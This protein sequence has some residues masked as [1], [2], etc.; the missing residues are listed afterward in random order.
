MR[1]LPVRDDAGVALVFAIGA[2]AV[3]STLILATSVLT[4]SSLRSSTAH[5]RFEGSL[6]AAE[7]GIDTTLN[8]VSE[9]YN[10]TPST[11]WTN[12]SPCTVAQPTSANLAS[13]DAERKWIHDAILAL[14]TSCTGHT[15][16]GDYVAVRPVGR[17]AVYSMGWSPS[18]S[19]GAKVRL[20][21]AEYVFSPYKPGNAILTNGS[22]DISGSVTVN[23]NDPT[24]PANVHTNA[25]ILGYNNSLN[26]A[27]T[28]SATGTLPGSC[29]HGVTGGCVAGDPLVRL[30][31]TDPRVV[32]NAFAATEPNWFDL[33]NG[34]VSGTGE[35]RR[36]GTSGPCSGSLIAT[37]NGSGNPLE[38]NGWTYAAGSGTT[39]ATW[40][41]P[42]TAGIYPGVYYVYRGDAVLGS[43]GNSPDTRALTVL[44]EAAPTGGTSATCNKLG[45]NITWKLFNLTPYLAGLMLDAQSSLY[46]QANASAG[47]GLFLAGDKVDLHTGSATVQGAVIA[48][49][50]CAAAGTNDLQ[51]QTITFD[52]TVETPVSDIIR[53]S[54]WLEYPSNT[55]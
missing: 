24:V 29:P 6:A 37:V 52:E 45:G 16:Q 3:I 34:S 23:A 31:A 12:P 9:A 18:R 40:T 47:A 35:V 14:P 36:P 10:G 26:V 27:G 4:V 54:L 43:N 48:S 28:V 51:G 11:V 55:S 38:F 33:C 41:L 15:P 17:Q 53:T 32:Y 1:R 20:I 49:N 25:S 19:T 13:P 22:V 21:K 42:R 50:N 2:A 39:P 46:G 8:L 5:T 30:P 44:A 7:A